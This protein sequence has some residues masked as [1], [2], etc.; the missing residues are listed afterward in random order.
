MV[1]ILLQSA[2]NIFRASKA[3]AGYRM[4]QQLCETVN[5]WRCYDYIIECF[6]VARFFPEE[7]RIVCDD[8]YCENINSKILHC[9]GNVT[10]DY[11]YNTH[12]G[13]YILNITK[14]L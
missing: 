4:L 14:T 1:T 9:I 3:A 8:G 6:R 2:G 11:I 12:D 10:I 5:R 13:Y 7:F